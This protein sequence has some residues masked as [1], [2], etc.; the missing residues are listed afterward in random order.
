MNILVTGIGGF[1][2][3]HVAKNLIYSGHKVIGIDNLNS[4]YDVNLKK[5]RLKKLKIYLKNDISK[6]SN[7]NLIFYKVT[8]FLLLFQLLY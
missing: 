5:N 2:G 7:D 8:S 6:F 1:I 4:Y 3:Y